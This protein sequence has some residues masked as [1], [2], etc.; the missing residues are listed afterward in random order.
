MIGLG[1]PYQEYWLSSYSKEIDIPVQLCI[2][3]GI[4]FLSG[5][6]KRA[7]RILIKFGLEWLHRLIMEP[8]RLWKRYIIGIPLFTFKVLII[9]I[10]LMLK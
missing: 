1:T 4:E 10:K 5:L 3:S 2:G 7:P 6:N 9:K 8:K